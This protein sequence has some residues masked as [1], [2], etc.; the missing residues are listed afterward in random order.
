MEEQ[1]IFSVGVDAL[2]ANQNRI[3]AEVFDLPGCGC[4]V[5]GMEDLD[6]TLTVAI[7]EHLVWLRSHG[8]DAGDP[9]SVKYEII[10]VVSAVADDIA[11]GEFCFEGDRLPVDA[12][13]VEEAI[14]LM[15]ASRRELLS[16]IGP[17][18]DVILDFLPPAVSVTTDEW[19]PEVRSIRGIVSHIAGAEGY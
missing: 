18:P 12:A 5:L 2:N 13:E 8:I 16:V 10:E 7:A 9:K 19:A 4:A 14:D 3:V 1:R 11:D 6:S 15:N 17:L